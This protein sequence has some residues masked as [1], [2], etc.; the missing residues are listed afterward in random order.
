MK[1]WLVDFLRPDDDPEASVAY[2]GFA[3]D[4]AACV[5]TPQTVA[6]LTALLSAAFWDTDVNS[7]AWLRFYAT[8]ARAVATADLTL[9]TLSAFGRLQLFLL[10]N[11]DLADAEQASDDP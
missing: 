6:R 4:V 10:D 11:C 3:A 2:S 5:R 9:S 8:L 7:D 1:D